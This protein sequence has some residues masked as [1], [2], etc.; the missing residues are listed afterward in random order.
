MSFECDAAI[1]VELQDVDTQPVVS[2]AKIL[3]VDDTP[4]NLVAAEAALEPLKRQIVTACS[5]QDAL[6]YLLEQEF[7]L[8]I[9]DVNM[10][11]MDGYETARWIRSRE[12]TQHLPIIFMTAHDHDDAAVL[13]AYELGAVDFLFKPVVAEVLRAK[14]SVFV[15]LHERTEALATERMERDFENRRRDYETLALRRERDRELAANKELA[16]LNE[17]LAEYDKRKDSFMAILAHELRNPLAPIRTSIDLIRADFAQPASSAKA[18][19][20]LERQTTVLVRLVDDLLDLSRIKADKIE[21]RPEAADL[22][23]LVEAALITSRPLLAERHHTVTVTAP[24]R[25]MVVADAVRITQ[26]ICNLLNNAARYTPPRGRIAV[27][28]GV[29]DDQLAFVRVQDNGIGIP[30]EL[31]TTIFKMFVQERVRS[32]GSGGLGLGLALSRRLIEMHH[33]AISCSSEGRDRGSTFEIHIPRYGSPLALP[34]RKR[35][36]D[37]A[38]LRHDPRDPKG[39]RTVVIDDNDDARELLSDLLRGKGYEVLTARDGSTGLGLI[40]EHQPHVALVDIGLPVLDGFGV[41]EALRKE[42]PGL[43]TRL[44]ALTGYGQSTDEDRTRSAGF[45]AHLI[46]PASAATILACLSQQLEES[47]PI[48]QGLSEAQAPA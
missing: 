16:R 27:I 28:A 38:P 8:V 33:G 41:V 32:D 31:Q 25:I 42:C 12:R 20:V 10:P 15:T 24:D 17:A 35:T 34:L 6:G 37:M 1:P 22:R 2:G 39:V 13:R 5:G 30:S 18:I 4:A 26:V 19:D 46:K 47:E 14:A 48:A 44:I 36:R 9:L 43:K 23:D 40:R 29:E 45:H 3:I 7:A 21:L 11:E